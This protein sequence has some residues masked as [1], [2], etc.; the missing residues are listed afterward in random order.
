MRLVQ[1]VE[2]LV[3]TTQDI[4]M[5]LKAVRYFMKNQIMNDDHE[6]AENMLII[7]I[8]N[9]IYAKN[10]NRTSLFHMCSV[11]TTFPFQIP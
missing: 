5:A 3:L 7:S 10:K 1:A 4:A 11:P 8:K 2:T 9:Q 6:Y